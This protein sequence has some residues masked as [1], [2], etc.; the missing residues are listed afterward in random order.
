MS[1]FYVD[2][3][4]GGLSAAVSKSVNAPI[5][6]VKL[7]LQNQDSNPDILSSGRR[8]TG[9]IDCFTRVASEEGVAAFWKGN[10]PN[11]I[12][13]FPT[14]FLNFA[15]KDSYKQLFKP[16]E[17]DA[18][19]WKKFSANLLSGACAGATSM[20]FVYPLDVAATRLANDISGQFKGLGDC[21]SFILNFGGITGLYTGFGTS[22]IGII[23]YRGFY[24]GFYDT[25]KAFM[26]K[27]GLANLAIALGVTNLAGLVSYPLDTIR[28]RMIMQV[29]RKIADIQYTGPLDCLFKILKQEGVGGL[30][31]GCLTNILRG[32][33]ASLVLV[34]FDH[35]FLAKRRDAI[36]K[37]QAEANKNK[38]GNQ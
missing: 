2:F 12:R 31:G 21:L 11:I 23:V 10:L 37:R 27:N 28:R 33:G 1:T 7:L 13:Y 36:K 18:P 19:H 30:F 22:V 24:F 35:F 38:E 34:L 14:Q 25:A 26:G 32:I 9:I 17:K 6:R 15:V 3:A 5:D 16:K 8:Y 20:L 29:G 4:L